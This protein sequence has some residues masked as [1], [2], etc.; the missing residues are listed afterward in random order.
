VLPFGFAVTRGTVERHPAAGI[1]GRDNHMQGSDVGGPGSPLPGAGALIALAELLHRLDNLGGLKE[2]SDAV[3]GFAVTHLGADLAGVSLRPPEGD[4]VRLAAS[5]A[6]LV[7]LDDAEGES[8]RALGW[9][10]PERGAL[11]SVADTRT[12]RRWPTWSSVVSRQRLLA[13]CLIEMTRLGGRPVTL[14]L[15]SRTAGA[16]DARELPGVAAFA[17]VIGLSVHHTERRSNLA[18]AMKT[19]DTIGQAQGILMER[20]G[21]TSEQAM[22]YLRRVSQ[23]SQQKVQDIATQLVQSAGRASPG[24]PPPKD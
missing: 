14:E 16:F 3:A 21:L 8:G 9:P 15:F 11:I 10:T 22:Q 4:S 17:R 1:E 19:R 7:R 20:Y 23:D 24:P 13:V 5:H 18:R 12:D 2:V 6:E